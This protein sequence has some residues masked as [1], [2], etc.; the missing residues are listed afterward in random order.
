MIWT[1]QRIKYLISDLTDENLFACHTLLSDLSISFTD[2]VK[3]LTISLEDR[4][5]LL[6][7][8]AFLQQNIH[9]EPDF[10]VII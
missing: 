5:E 1:E 10:K 6:L 7:N 3:T 2:E 9:T 8:P 4:P